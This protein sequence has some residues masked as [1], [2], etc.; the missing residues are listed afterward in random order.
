MVY[1]A[2]GIVFGNF[3]RFQLARSTSQNNISVGNGIN[4]FSKLDPHERRFAGD[5]NALWHVSLV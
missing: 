2:M 3:F 4:G 1:P 5:R